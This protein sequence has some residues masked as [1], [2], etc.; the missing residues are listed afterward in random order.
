MTGWRWRVRERDSV[1]LGEGTI[2]RFREYR[3]RSSS[4]QVTGKGQG[5]GGRVHL[6]D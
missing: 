4:G 2:Y 3:K 6:I 1:V 5:G